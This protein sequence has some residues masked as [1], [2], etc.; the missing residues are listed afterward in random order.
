MA[1]KAIALIK[2]A[3]ILDMLASG[4]RLSDIAPKF[5]VTP[6]AISAPLVND[7]EYKAS[8]MMGFEQRLDK[9]EN[10]ISIATDALEVSRA[11]EYFRALSWRAER[12]ARE[13]YGA[14]L[15]V[16]VNIDISGALDDARQ[17]AQRVVRSTIQGE[18]E[19]I[20]DQGQEDDT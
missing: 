14:N 19:R 2:R 15:Q 3:E 10:D 16:S 8:I 4:L 9:A 12:E 5:G 11:R 6:Q 17:R 18:S 20:L 13:K 7:P 1:T